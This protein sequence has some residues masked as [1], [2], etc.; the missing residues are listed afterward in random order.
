MNVDNERVTVM[1]AHPTIEW[2]A[3]QVPSGR[4]RRLPISFTTEIEFMA[5]FFTRRIHVMGIRDRPTAAGSPWQNGYAER[6]I[7]SIRPECLD[8]GDRVRRASSPPSPPRL[9]RLS[10]R[11]RT[12]LAIEGRANSQSYSGHWTHSALPVLNELYYFLCP[13]LISDSSSD[14]P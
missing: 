12:H 7:G 1:T 6:L 3:Y 14:D 5:R 9:C 13:D 8:Q 4:T 10:N 2:I 11:T